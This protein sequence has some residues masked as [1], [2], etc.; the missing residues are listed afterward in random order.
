MTGLLNRTS[1]R[2]TLHHAI[3]QSERLGLPATLLM[4][5]LDHFKSINDNYG[6]SIGDTV[7]RDVG[8]H[9]GERIRHSDKVFRLGGEE[10][11]IVLY[12]TET[13]SA[14]EVAEELRNGVAMLSTPLD[15]AITASIGLATHLPG[16][17][18]DEWLKRCDDMLYQ[19]KSA[20]RNKVIF[21]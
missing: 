8:T 14:I 7:L 15:S 1:L 5:D 21:Q 16:E 19:A 3:S 20:G 17:G 6:H 11:L 12:N 10:F 13:E 18:M 4:L 9:L 2:E